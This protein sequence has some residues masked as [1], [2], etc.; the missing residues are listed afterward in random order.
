MLGVVRPLSILTAATGRVAAGELDTPVP[1]TGRTDELGGLARALEVF[2]GQARDKRRL[3]AEA[4]E[5]AARAEAQ[6]HAALEAMA[7]TVE[8]ETRLAVDQVAA[9]TEEMAGHARSMAG[10]AGLVAQNSQGV[11]AAAEQALHNAETVA[12]ASEELA[13]SIREISAQVSHAGEVSRAA[14]ERGVAAEA[15]IGSL[16]EAVARIGDVAVLIGEVASQTNLLALN[17]TIEAARAGEA[18]K[19]FAVVAGEVKGLASQTARSTEEIT[20]QIQEVQAATR[21]AVEAVASI[22]V[23]VR[24][25]DQVSGAIA[26]A[27]EEQGAATQEISRNVTQAAEAAREVSARIAEVSAEAGTS[28]DRA[29]TVQAAASDIAHGITDLRTMLVRVVRTSIADVDRRAAPRVALARPCVV[30]VAGRQ[31][32]GTLADLSAG[33]ACISLDEPLPVGTRGSLSIPGLAVSPAFTVLE[34]DARGLH[35]RFDGLSPAHRSAL[36]TLLRQAA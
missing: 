31:V 25:M 6:K 22:G 5:N 27:I 4:A 7:A 17:A 1:G 33:G 36:E 13:A 21:H 35:V 11:A 30:D 15:I 9:R 8:R 24:D 32:E 3:E 34:A 19:G 14:V 20:R 23:A 2:R 26:A 18:G 16:S 12:S 29:G 28:G 10:S